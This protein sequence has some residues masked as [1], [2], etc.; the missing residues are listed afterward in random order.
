MSDLGEFSIE[1]CRFDCKE[2]MRSTCTI[3]KCGIGGPLVNRSGEV[4]GINFFSSEFTPSLP[5]NIVSKWWGHYKKFG[6]YR[7]P[8]LGLELRNLYSATIDILEKITRNFPDIRKGVI[9]DEVT[10][11]SPAHSAGVHPDDI[12]VECDGQIVQSS[13]QFF[14]ITWDKVGKMVELV[15]LRG[16]GARMKSSIMVDIIS[17]YQFNSWPLERPRRDWSKMFS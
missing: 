6:D 2:L 1:Q 17:P 4:I 11:D 15:V 7:R 5:I 12:I 10:Q 13:L 3:P 16:D 8:W 14:D 9:I